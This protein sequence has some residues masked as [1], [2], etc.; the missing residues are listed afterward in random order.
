MAVLYPIAYSFHINCELLYVQNKFV[1]GKSADRIRGTGT[2][3]F[4]SLVRSQSSSCVHMPVLYPIA[5]GSGCTQTGV[6]LGKEVSS[7]LK[8]LNAIEL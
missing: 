2:H 8:Q 4:M 5:A 1:F 3:L 7:L 6:I